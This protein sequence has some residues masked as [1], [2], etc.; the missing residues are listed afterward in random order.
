MPTKMSQDS[1][2]DVLVLNTCYD[3]DRSTAVAADLNVDTE[4]TSQSLGPGHRRMTLVGLSFRRRT[5][6]LFGSLAALG[7]GYRNVRCLE[8]ANDLRL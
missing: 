1:V 7:A 2:Y 4:H 8:L 5:A 3:S 6:M